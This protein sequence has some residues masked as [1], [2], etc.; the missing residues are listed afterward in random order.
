MGHQ[1][2]RNPRS[3]GRPS[4][5]GPGSFTVKDQLGRPLQEGD[6]VSHLAY[7]GMLGIVRSVR[8]ALEPGYPANAVRAIV[9]FQPYIVEAPSGQVLPLL[10]VKPAEEVREEQQEA[11]REAGRVNGV[12][13]GDPVQEGPGQEGPAQAPSPGPQDPRGDVGDVVRQG[14]K[15][16]IT[17]QE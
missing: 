2:R 4:V 14:P 11:Q 17:D 13:M 7:N 5:L 10:L 1:A 8:P 15:L 16:V 9:D 12:E 3:F 6:I